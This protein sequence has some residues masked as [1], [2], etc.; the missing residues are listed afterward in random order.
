MMVWQRLGRCP[1]LY[2]WLPLLG[3]MGQIFYLSAQQKLPTS[4]SGWLDEV[5]S[6]GA[7]AGVFAVLALLWMRIVGHHPRGWLLAFSLTGLYAL[8][9]EFHQSFVPGRHPDPWDLLCDGAGAALALGLWAW[10]QSGRLLPGHKRPDQ[11]PA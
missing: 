2:L 3:W 4:G 6:S 7:H 8:S 5:M 10:F 1:L 9:D 11:P